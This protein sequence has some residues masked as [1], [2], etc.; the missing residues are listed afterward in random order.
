MA[1]Y[2]KHGI[3]ILHG[4]ARRKLR[5]VRQVD[6]VLTDPPYGIKLQGLRGKDCR[7]VGDEDQQLEHWHPVP[8]VIQQ[9]PEA[10]AMLSIVSPGFNSARYTA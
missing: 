5:W 10:S 7:I 3:T 2:R 8:V 6:L 9:T 4:D 1:Y